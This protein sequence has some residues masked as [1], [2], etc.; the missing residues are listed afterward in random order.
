MT[1]ENRNIRLTI[2]KMISEAGASHVASAFSAVEILNAVFKSVDIA[3]IKAKDNGR[4]RVILS[5]GH[6]A[7]ALY[8][9]MARHG[10]LSEKDLATYCKNGSLLQGHA[11]HHV[12]YVEHSTGSLGHGVPVALG[13]AIGLLSRGFNGRAFVITGDAELQ[14]GS[15]WE[16]FMLAG[17]LKLN[18]YCVLVDNNNI[19]Q[20]GEFVDWC[21]IQ[22]ITDKFKSFRF[23]VIEVDGNNE[24]EIMSAIQ[25]LGTMESPLAIVCHT[26]KGKGVSFMESN[27]VWHY[28]PPQGEDYE[29]AVTELKSI[30]T[31]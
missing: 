11:S 5:K 6:G 15:N 2:L 22:P 23:H 1:E 31:T 19:S 29:K 4:D 14:E 27:A 16:A 26:T 24:A 12:P 21:D 28:R 7:A 20:M 17:Q 8:A 25:K 18:D 9:V 10:L 3:K 13:M 30:Q